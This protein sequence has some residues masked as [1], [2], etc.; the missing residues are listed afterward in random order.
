[1]KQQKE[2][3][4]NKD[5]TDTRHKLRVFFG[6]IKFK[7]KKQIDIVKHPVITSRADVSD[8]MIKNAK[9]RT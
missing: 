7:K 4:N 5:N 1:M 9:H 3:V 8:E 2:T 6:G